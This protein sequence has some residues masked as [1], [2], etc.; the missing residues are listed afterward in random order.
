MNTNQVSR[1]AGSFFCPCC[2]RTD[3][4]DD[5]DVDGL[6]GEA[7]EEGE[8]EA[9]NSSSGLRR[10]TAGSRAVAVS[11]MGSSE[12]ELSHLSHLSRSQ[13]L[14]SQHTNEEHD[15]EHD[16]EP[17]D[18]ENGRLTVVP[19]VVVT[20]VPDSLGDNSGS[21]V[22]HSSEILLD[23]GVR[24]HSRLRPHSSAR[25]HSSEVLLSS[26]NML[27][28][29]TGT[30]RTSHD[31]SEILLDS[32]SRD[33]ADPIWRDSEI[34]EEKT[35]IFSL[36]A[37]FPREQSVQVQREVVDLQEVVSNSSSGNA[38]RPRKN[39]GGSYNFIGGTLEKRVSGG[40]K[41]YGEKSKKAQN[42]RW[43]LLD[44]AMAQMTGLK[45]ETR[46]PQAFERYEDATR[47]PMG[48][49]SGW[50][51]D[52]DYGGGGNVNS[53]Y[54]GGGLVNLNN[55]NSSKYRGA[56]AYRARRLSVDPRHKDAIL[57]RGWFRRT[58][59]YKIHLKGLV[60]AAAVLGTLLFMALVGFLVY[61]GLV[62]EQETGGVV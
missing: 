12:R 48:W 50:Y 61:E 45:M 62:R 16:E 37:E 7:G 20:A 13:E 31:G 39:F 10:T 29:P 57:R 59:C 15:E 53:D 38:G 54:Y 25:P 3:D 55:L 49:R 46:T 4:G 41:K 2:A 47:H 42:A 32:S 44:A 18:A 30:P 23:S 43:S 52:E 33:Y 56:T 22:K 24:P 40:P 8:E 5:S 19:H 1:R 36:T 11:K 35:E 14:L 60:I 17:E 6:A 58:C 9:L 26:G 27:H 34:L 51:W 21:A 28:A